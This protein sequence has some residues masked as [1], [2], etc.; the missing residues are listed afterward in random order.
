M[1]TSPRSDRGSTHGTAITIPI[2]DVTTHPHPASPTSTLA[3]PS[4]PRRTLAS[5]RDQLASELSYRAIARGETIDGARIGVLLTLS[6]S[7]SEGFLRALAH[8]IKHT[9]LLQRWVFALATTSTGGGVNVLLLCGSGED[10]VQRAVLLAS[11]KFLDRVEGVSDEGKR[12]VAR[13]RDTGTCAYDKVALWDVVRKAAREPMDPYHAPPGS[14]GIDE[15]LLEARSKLTRITPEDAYEELQDPT[16]PMP[17]FLVDIRPEAQRAAHGGIHGSLLI[18]RNVLEWRFD[19]RHPA[20]L[21][22]ADRYDLRV[23]VLCQ[24]GYTSSLAAA[25]LHELGLLNATDVVGG[26]RAW[27]EK[28]LPTHINHSRWVP[29][30]GSAT[31]DKSSQ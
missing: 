25:A 10:V 31:T 1:P 22:C 17:V 20:R 16:Y 12:W 15:M 13:V 21:S 19:P 4:T 27:Q 3:S 29:D 24:E 5:V 6:K 14:R 26:F 8:K 30:G 23:I 7:D 2:L 18:E 28:G 9:L 11:A